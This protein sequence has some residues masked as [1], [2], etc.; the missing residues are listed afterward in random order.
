[1]PKRTPRI[2]GVVYLISNSGIKHQYFRKL[3]DDSLW[4]MLVAIT[5]LHMPQYHSPLKCYDCHGP[6]AIGANVR[7]NNFT[8]PDLVS[9]NCENQT[10]TCEAIADWP[11]KVEGAGAESKVHRVCSTPGDTAASA[12]VGKCKPMNRTGRIGVTCYCN[13]DCCNGWLF[14]DLLKQHGD[15]N[16]LGNSTCEGLLPSINAS[17]PVSGGHHK[18]STGSIHQISSVFFVAEALVCTALTLSCGIGIT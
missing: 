3:M 16:P 15:Y 14:M 12:S 18:K 8:D 2:F 13:T 5:M 1:M 6:Y 7:C 4:L 11:E 9:I 17:T 10:T